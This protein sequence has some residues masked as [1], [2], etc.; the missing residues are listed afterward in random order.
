MKGDTGATGAAGPAGVK[1]DTGATGATGPAGPQGAAGAKGDTGAQ[2]IQGPSGA[3]GDTGQ[4]GDTGPKG[5]GPRTGDTGP[6]GPKGDTGPAGSLTGPAGGVLA[7]T[8][9]DPSF[10]PAALDTFVQGSHE[11]V[12]PT[13][14]SA[15]IGTTTIRQRPGRYEMEWVCPSDETVG[16]TFFVH[17]TSTTTM[18]V[19]V[20]SQHQLVES[21][22][23]PDDS[24]TP[25]SFGAPD[26]L[27]VEVTGPS[28]SV[29]SIFFFDRV[30][31]CNVNGHTFEQL[32]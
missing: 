1:G 16:G 9:P 7:G 8:Y 24:T 4:T 23:A 6:A 28:E 5:D 10:G 32:N 30:S 29:T 18:R 31:G 22:V 27:I 11:F 14:L 3:K 13:S 2:G 15:P 21:D 20:E 12:E 19:F 17:N 25:V 26:R